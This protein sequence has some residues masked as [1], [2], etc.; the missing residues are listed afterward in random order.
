MRNPAI[1]PEQRSACMVLDIVVH[2]FQR[3][4]GETLHV[5]QLA[6]RWRMRGGDSQQMC[7]GL[8]YACAR[9]WIDGLHHG[10]R[11]TKMG[12][13]MANATHTPL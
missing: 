3:M 1:D 13:H 2:D 5:Q 12:Y 11:L 8:T 4:P 10:F 7:A 6:E 9:Q